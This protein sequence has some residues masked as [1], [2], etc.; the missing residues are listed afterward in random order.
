MASGNPLRFTFFAT[1]PNA[2]SRMQ[3]FRADH[4]RHLIESGDLTLWCGTC[5]TSWKASDELLA[6]IERLVPL[7]E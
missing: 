1:C 3:S 2:H 4:L 7:Q 6:R 5:D